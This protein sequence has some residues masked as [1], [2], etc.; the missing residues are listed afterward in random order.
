M[1]AGLAAEAAFA[2]LARAFHGFTVD[3][4]NP[5]HVTFDP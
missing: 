5:L 2:A 4:T 1:P 3:E